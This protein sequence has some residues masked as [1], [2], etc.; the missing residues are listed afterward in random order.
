MP[1]PNSAT[2]TPPTDP[3]TSPFLELEALAGPVPDLASTLTTTQAEQDANDDNVSFLRSPIPQSDI[4]VSSNMDRLYREQLRREREFRLAQHRGSESQRRMHTGTASNERRY[5]PSEL[6]ELQDRAL[7]LTQ[8]SS[9]G[10]QGWAPQDGRSDSENQHGLP[11]M[12]RSSAEF[13]DDHRRALVSFARHLESSNRDS[14]TSGARA[15]AASP[16]HTTPESL[17]TAALLQSVRSSHLSARSRSV[18]QNHLLERERSGLE[19]T[20]SRDQYSTSDQ[21]R[22]SALGS[23]SGR[24]RDHSPSSMSSTLHDQAR[25]DWVMNGTHRQQEEEELQRRQEGSTWNLEDAIKYLERLRFCDSS[26]DSL[27]SATAGA[28]TSEELLDTDH[29]DFISDTAMIDPPAESSWLKIGGIFSGSQHATHGSSHLVR[30]RSDARG[31]RHTDLPQLGQAQ[32]LPTNRHSFSYT[33]SNPATRSSGTYSRNRA[34]LAFFENVDEASPQFRTLPL[35]SAA[36]RSLVQSS[37]AKPSE[38]RW[39]VQVR[40]HSIDYETMTL[41][42]TMEAFNVP[43]QNSVTQKSSITTFLEGEIIDFNKF[44]LKT[45]SYKTDENTDSIY[46]RMLEPFKKLTDDEMV[47]GLLSKRWMREQLWERYILMRWKEKCFVKPLDAHA[48]LTI[49]GFYYV[50]MRRSDGR[51]ESLYYDPQSAPFQHLSMMPEGK[52]QFPSYQFT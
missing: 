39:P 35:N 37:S 3:S 4:G 41:T 45:K 7:S 14:P 22:R 36:E 29:D 24:Q 32:T 50:S 10:Y 33:V 30:N 21:R 42:G 43:D 1:P 46:W 11:T 15:S 25:R 34:S 20:A 6:R 16:T 47:R 40:I 18:M 2:A 19:S 26:E 52:R 12:S 44:T 51:I 31:S 23:R 49:S 5:S 27:S 17:R 38:E 9:S 13:Y 28:F 48:L 8:R